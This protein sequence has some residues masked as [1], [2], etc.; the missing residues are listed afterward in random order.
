MQ[1]RGIRLP[2]APKAI[3]VGESIE[4]IKA[5]DLPMAMLPT[6]ISHFR[7]TEIELKTADKEYAHQLSRGCK[8]F[9]VQ[10]RDGTAVRVATAPDIVKN[11]NPGYWTLKGGV[12]S[13]SNSQVWKE[14][15]L[16]IRDDNMLLYFA[17]ASGDKFLEII[18]GF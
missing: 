16:D 6:K 1:E 12:A 7:I 5:E 14:D 3:F 9:K 2:R 13:G 15:N 10:C 17:C 11:S 4:E 18:E 8:R